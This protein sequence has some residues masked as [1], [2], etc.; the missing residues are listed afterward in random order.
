M[1]TIYYECMYGPRDCA[2][3]AWYSKVIEARGMT[4][5]EVR[6]DAQRQ[7]DALGGF[8]L[9]AVGLMNRRADW[10]AAF[11]PTDMPDTSFAIR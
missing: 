4:G 1:L 2:I 10:E 7:C 3:T 5:E 8:N 6:A 9:I 11:G